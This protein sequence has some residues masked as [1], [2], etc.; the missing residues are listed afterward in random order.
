MFIYLHP[1]LAHMPKNFTVKEEVFEYLSN[2]KRENE[3]YSD[4][5]LRLKRNQ[6][7]KSLL[8]LCGSCPDAKQVRTE[9]E[10]NWL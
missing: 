10:D 4:V 5:I 3:S 6:S 8:E 9:F 1:L 2:I 7:Q